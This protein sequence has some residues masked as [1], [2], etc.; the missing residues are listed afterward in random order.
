MHQPEFGKVAAEGKHCKKWTDFY[1]FIA[2]DSIIK[3]R[4]FG[5]DNIVKD[6]W[7]LYERSCRK[8]QKTS[9]NHSIFCGFNLWIFTSLSEQQT[10]GRKR[11][12][13]KRWQGFAVLWWNLLRCWR[14]SNRWSISRW[15][16]VA[17]KSLIQSAKGDN[18]QG[19]FGKWS[20]YIC[21]R[22]VFP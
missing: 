7:D 19:F 16:N 22:G 10:D 20:F 5:K 13:S 9:P 3:R 17:E 6:W 14:C 4:G 15:Q 11:A 18:Q 8:L 2:D 1:C 12:V 21:P